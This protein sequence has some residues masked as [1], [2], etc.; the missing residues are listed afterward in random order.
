[1][2]K[3][4]Q[5]LKFHPYTSHLAVMHKSDWRFVVAGVM[6]CAVLCS[7][8]S[9]WDIEDGIKLVAQYNSPARITAA[10]FLNPHDISLLLT[11]S[12]QSCFN[13][14][15]KTSSFIAFVYRKH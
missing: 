8:C 12:G 7:Y 6:C 5:L 11:G 4:P 10:E 2:E 14:L 13:T 15:A 3:T 1:M 9:V